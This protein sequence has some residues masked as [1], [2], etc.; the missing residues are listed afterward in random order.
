MNI[1]GIVSSIGHAN[2]KDLSVS[3]RAICSFSLFGLFVILTILPSGRRLYTL[4]MYLS[5]SS[6]VAKVSL[7]S[8]SSGSSSLTFPFISSP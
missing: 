7:Y 5:L 6:F 1:F 4:L 8:P 2:T 3:I